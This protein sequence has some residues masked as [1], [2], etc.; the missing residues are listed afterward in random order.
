MNIIKNTSKK[1]CVTVMLLASMVSF[2]AGSINAQDIFADLAGVDNVESTYVSGRFAHNKKIWASSSGQHSI[3]LDKGFSSFYSYQC[4][5]EKSVAMARKILKQ[6][7]KDNPSVEVMMR[8]SQGVQ[9]YA[10]YEKF[11]DD[12]DKITQMV[13]WNSDAPNIAEVSV[14][15]WN[16]GLVRTKSKYE[17][18]DETDEDE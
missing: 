16:K 8:T 17:D 1:Y 2:M 9:E 14:I 18:Y 11:T 3:R 4:Y 5:S 15:N 7:L 13:I 10:V 12:G 6:Y